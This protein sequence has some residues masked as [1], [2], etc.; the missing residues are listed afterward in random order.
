MKTPIQPLGD[1]IV[2]KKQE[3]KTQTASGIFLPDSAKEKPVAAEVV[4]IGPKVENI[5]IGDEIIY[6][7]YAPTELKIDNI[8]YLVIK[9]EDVLA[10]LI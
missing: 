7:E 9:E 6:R 2:A 8:E 10:K 3:K 4:A 1:R 5:T